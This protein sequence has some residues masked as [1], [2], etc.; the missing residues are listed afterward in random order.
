MQMTTL[1]KG[2]FQIYDA[3]D[4]NYELSELGVTSE[5]RVEQRVR[6]TGEN[7]HVDYVHIAE[8][9]FP[10]PLPFNVVFA[11][12]G[13]FKKFVKLFSSEPEVGDPLFDDNVYITTNDPQAVLTTLTER[14]QGA[15]L[16]F[17]QQHGYVKING[18]QLE[19]EIV[20]PDDDIRSDSQMIEQHVLVAHFLQW[21]L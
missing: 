9:T 1:F 12:E 18:G 17:V 14:C 5:H 20:N 3:D 6:H 2:A 10:Q 21:V 8:W 11:K 15:V 16:N 13:L 4:P 19:I 7:R